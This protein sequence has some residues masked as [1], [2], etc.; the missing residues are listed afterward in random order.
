M[1]NEINKAIKKISKPNEVRIFKAMAK[2]LTSRYASACFVKESHRC[3][4]R[5]NSCA[6]NK[7]VKR[8]ISDLVIVSY[9]KNSVKLCF[10]Q[11]KYHRTSIQ[12]KRF[13]DFTGDY[14][15][16]ELL[17]SRPKIEN[18]G[19]KL[20]FPPNILSFTKYNSI[21]SFG[22]FYRDSKGKIDML[23]SIAKLIK[24]KA[25]K[26]D[27]KNAKA[28]LCFPGT[29]SCPKIAYKNQSERE[30]FSTCY[31]N[32]FEKG[33]LLHKIGAPVN[34]NSEA[35]SFIAGILTAAK[36]NNNDPDLNRM[37]DEVM[38]LLRI[39]KPLPFRDNPN[40]LLVKSPG[41]LIR[42]MLKAL[43]HGDSI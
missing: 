22:V 16:W 7:S 18:C 38:R 42:A 31:I 5:Y 40:I 12:G 29:S 20:C 25:V 10:L 15:Q 41:C 21:G 34:S 35:A 23:Y 43:D 14:F 3:Y 37:T 27:P 32:Q 39:D 36:S 4:V 26:C 19:R 33:L 9:L 30:M 24:P 17:N 1:K 8:E 6:A 13:L 28:T 11:A 2:S